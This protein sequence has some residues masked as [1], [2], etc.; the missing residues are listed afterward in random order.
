[1]GLLLGFYSCNLSNINHYLSKPFLVVNSKKSINADVFYE[2][3]VFA[4]K[5][6]K[7]S[8]KYINYL[9]IV[10]VVGIINR[11]IIKANELIRSI[12]KIEC[13]KIKYQRFFLV[14]FCV[15]KKIVYIGRIDI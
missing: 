8:F 10:G 6:H 5:L 13:Y 2:K 7:Y 3:L 4:D 9:T 14:K 12:N 1:M 15:N 11:H